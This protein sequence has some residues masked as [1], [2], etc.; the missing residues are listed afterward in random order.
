MLSDAALD[1]RKSREDHG[2]REEDG[3]GQSWVITAYYV[4]TVYV[5]YMYT[6]MNIAGVQTTSL[7]TPCIAIPR[8]LYQSACKLYLI[9][10][11]SET[12]RST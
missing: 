10:Q 5:W 12:T 4:Y 8:E 9:M 11:R 6:F 7:L 3:Q 1:V 2:V